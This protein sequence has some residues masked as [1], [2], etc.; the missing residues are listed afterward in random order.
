MAAGY[1]STSPK[2]IVPK[3]RLDISLSSTTCLLHRSNPPSPWG[4]CQSVGCRLLFVHGNKRPR[5]TWHDSARDFRAHGDP[6]GKTSHNNCPPRELIPQMCTLIGLSLG[7]GSGPGRAAEL[8]PGSSARTGRHP[9]CILLCILHPALD[10]SL[11]LL[12]SISYPIE[13]CAGVNSPAAI[14]WGELCFFCY[15]VSASER[16][17]CLLPL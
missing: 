3:P 13:I 9:A 10:L 6:T 12:S 1:C 14:A 17:Y 16:S 15:S 11:A 2:G 4:S 5:V 8:H 7:Y